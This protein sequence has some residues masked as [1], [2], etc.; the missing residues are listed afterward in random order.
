MK[1]KF[2][3]YCTMVGGILLML[4]F[5][6]HF[7][8]GYPAVSDLLRKENAD[9]DLTFSVQNIWIFSSITMLLCGIWATFLGYH[10]LKTNSRKRLEQLLLGLGITLFA[11]IGWLHP[12]S[13]W[14]LFI[15]FFPGLLI[16]VPGLFRQH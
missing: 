11:L 4:F 15:F 1:S 12:F 5:I 8:L 10:A 2:A 7:F 9:A 14:Q 3:A 16:L 13:N 6:P